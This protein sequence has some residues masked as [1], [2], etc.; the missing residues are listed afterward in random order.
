[1]NDLARKK[2]MHDLAKGLLADKAFQ[3]A[4]IDLRKRWYDQ[5]LASPPG[6]ERDELIVK[7][8]ALDELAPE[9]DLL[10]NDYK[11]ALSRQQ[12]HG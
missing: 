7:S 3:Q 6:P 4:I 11:M 1:M 12:K 10:M 5:I 2:E 9:L 8:K